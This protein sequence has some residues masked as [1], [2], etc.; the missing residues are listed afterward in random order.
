MHETHHD[1]EQRIIT[2]KVSNI[3]LAE[4]TLVPSVVLFRPPVGHRYIVLD[5]ITEAKTITGTLTDAP[6][7]A[8]DNGTTGQDIVTSLDQ[9]VAVG[10]Q[11]LTVIAAPKIVD[12]DKPLRL[13]KT[14]ISEGCTSYKLSITV[15]LI[16][17]SG[18]GV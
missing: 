14:E 11:R 16:R 4:V 10:V 17:I 3:E 18:S 8:L 7:I 12:N 15:A 9:P 2:K 5:A 1:T 6:K 13:L